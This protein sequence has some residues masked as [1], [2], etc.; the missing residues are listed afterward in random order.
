MARTL[1]LLR[2]VS[3]LAQHFRLAVVLATILLLSGVMYVAMEPEA[4]ATYSLVRTVHHQG[5]SELILCMMML[6]VGTASLVLLVGECRKREPDPLLVLLYAAL[7][8]ASWAVVHYVYLL[9]R[10]L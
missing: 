2:R 4:A 10:G 1:K 3:W 8:F 5:L 9:K 6:G 7:C